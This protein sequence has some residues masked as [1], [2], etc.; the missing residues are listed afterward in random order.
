VGICSYWTYSAVSTLVEILRSKDEDPHIKCR[1]LQA[2]ALLAESA[3]YPLLTF[4]ELYILPLLAD[5]ALYRGR[6]S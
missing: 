4:L 5:I 6:K 3:Q 1:A 2:A